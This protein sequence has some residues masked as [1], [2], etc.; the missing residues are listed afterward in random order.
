MSSHPFRPSL[1]P[2][3]SFSSFFPPKFPSLLVLPPQ[4][5]GLCRSFSFEH[6]FLLASGA[7]MA[8]SFQTDMRERFYRWRGPFHVLVLVQFRVES[9]WYNSWW[10]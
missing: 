6:S 3:F 4:L 9:G 1:P 5:L 8:H 7:M 10:W 2:F